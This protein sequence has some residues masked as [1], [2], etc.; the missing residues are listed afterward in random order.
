MDLQIGEYVIPD[1]CTVRRTGNV[2]QVYKRRDKKYM[3]N[4]DNPRCRN[5]IHFVSGHTKY[6][7]WTTMVCD[8]KPKVLRKEET[9]YYKDMKL[10]FCARPYDKPCDK[11]VRK[12][13]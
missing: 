4:Y 10:Y 1:G 5:C 7:Y 2:L 6:G 13:K 8:A 9:G 3:V 12:E 11:Y